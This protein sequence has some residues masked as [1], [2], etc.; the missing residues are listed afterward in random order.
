MC[1]QSGCRI[2]LT[3]LRFTSSEKMFAELFL[4]LS[5]D[6]ERVDEWRVAKV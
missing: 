5:E 3:K 6:D 2:L 4:Y 1:V